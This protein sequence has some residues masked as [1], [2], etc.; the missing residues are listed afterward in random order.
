MA[1]ESR[2]ACPVPGAPS[3]TVSAG[4]PRRH[5]LRRQLEQRLVAWSQPTPLLEPSGDA[6]DQYHRYKDDLRLLAELGFDNYRFSVEWSRVEP[7]EGEFSRAAL[8]HYRRV[9]AFA[10]EVGVAPVVTFHHFTSPRW[11]AAAGG[12]TEPAT[13]DRFARFCERTTATSVISWA[14]L[15]INEPNI[16]APRHCRRLPSGVAGPRAPASGQRCVHRRAPQA[17]DAIHAGPATRGRVDAAMTN[18]QAWRVGSQ[19]RPIR[20]GMQDCFRRP[21]AATTSSAC[22]PTAASGSGPT[23]RWARGGR[24]DDDH[25]LRFLAEALEATIRREW[26]VTEQTPILVTENGIAPPTTPPHRVRA[27]GWRRA[28]LPGRP[29]RGARLHVLERPGQLRMGPR[30]RADLRPDRGRP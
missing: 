27:A 24:R 16:V 2:V 3:R 9:C 12:W 8:E 11:V 26:E 22:R 19:A 6:C 21:V 10:R 7:E 15:P 25:G 4:C 30:V 20:R 5:Q 29:D 23:A 13:A 17:S 14:G 28:A 1:G 18:Y